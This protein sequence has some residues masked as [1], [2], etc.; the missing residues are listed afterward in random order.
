MLLWAVMSINP[1][2]VG[3]VGP[4]GR[5]GAISQGD[6]GLSPAKRLLWQ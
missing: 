5:R 1:S 4:V 6:E 3:Q 2:A